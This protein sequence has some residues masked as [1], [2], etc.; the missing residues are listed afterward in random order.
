MAKT[1]E[2]P[3][4]PGQKEVGQGWAGR[5]ELRMMPLSELKPWAKNPRNNKAAVAKVAASIRQFGFA[6]PIV[7][8]MATSVII[9]GHTRWEAAHLLGLSEIPVRLLDLSEREA[10]MLA[11]ADNRLGEIATWDDQMLASLL[12][13]MEQEGQD[14]S[15]AGFEPDEIG[16]LLGSLEAEQREKVKL[17]ARFIVPPFSV[18]DAR[19]GYWQERKAEWL[20]LGIKSEVGR[21][22]NL[23]KMSDT[24]LQPDAVARA[25]AGLNSQLD[26]K[27]KKA[28]GAYAAGFGGGGVLS[29]GDGGSGS[30][31][32]SIFDP[33]L[34]ELAYRWFSP[35]GGLVL[36]PFA[37]GSVRGIVASRTGRRYLGIDLRQEQVEA[38]LEQ[39][40]KLCGA[41]ASSQAGEAGGPMPEWHCGDSRDIDNIAQGVEADF[42]F[43]CPPYADL[44]VY[45]DDPRDL[46]TL[47][48]EKFLEAYRTIIAKACGK[49][50]A[51]RFAAFVVGDVRDKKG[52]YRNFVSHTIDAFE[53]AGLRLYNEAI[54][55]T[56]CGTLAL[57]AGGAFSASR[58]LGKTHQNVLVFLHG[59]AKKATAACGAV[60]IMVP[61]EE[62]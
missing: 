3:A 61:E 28:L 50:K 8:R 25:R 35:P 20:S 5:A 49:L 39:A 41:E 27:G 31:G 24:M 37:G 34:C 44:E 11:L 47:G 55:V 29:R 26:E 10:E 59:D 58:K 30:T 12:R 17:S 62:A 9:A 22:E 1:R 14:L 18:L 54:L 57:R 38:N 40:E 36:D 43:S 4:Q 45:S 15:V 52:L 6:A 19:S 16:A 33:V 21:G 56:P 51:N 32:T 23:L 60:E 2:N 13:Q 42:V 7:A 48:Y 53:A 46:S